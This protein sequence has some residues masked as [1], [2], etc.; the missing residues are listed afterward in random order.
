MTLIGDGISI[1]GY[2][3]DGT[4]TVTIEPKTGTK[5][6]NIGGADAYNATAS[7]GDVGLSLPELNYITAGTLDF[8]T[9]TAGSGYGI[10]GNVTV[11]AAITRPGATNLNVAT[12]G[13][14]AFSAIDS[15]NAAGGNVSLTTA[16]A[17]ITAGDNVT[18]EVTANT[19][20][21]AAGSGNVALGR[22]AQ[23]LRQH[24]QHRGDLRHGH[25]HQPELHRGRAI[26]Q[27]SGPQTISTPVTLIAADTVAL[28]VAKPQPATTRFRSPAAGR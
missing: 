19:L 22:P 6:I 12:G 18:T 2:L 5:P 17:N 13:T 4:G 27:Y 24:G 23:C 7:S 9:T 10:S 26:V 14:I 28:K 25:P 1:G 21:I 15:I 11:S 20:T 16:N 3:N 8:G